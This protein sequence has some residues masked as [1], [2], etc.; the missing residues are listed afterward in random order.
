MPVLADDG[1]VGRAEDEPQGERSDDRV[2]ERADDRDE[3][4]NKVDGR[5]EPEARDADDDLRGEAHAPVAQQSSEETDQVREEKGELTRKKDAADDDEY[6]D[7][8]D[9][10]RDEDPK[11]DRPDRKI[12]DQFA[13][14]RSASDVGIEPV[15]VMASWNARRAARSAA[16]R[17]ASQ[18]VRMSMI[19]SIPVR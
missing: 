10:D 14:A 11:H 19:S 18:R 16:P 7:D 4:G 9:P 6:H 1:G 2:I 5:G 3:L 12:H 17:F 15:D 13:I 8:D